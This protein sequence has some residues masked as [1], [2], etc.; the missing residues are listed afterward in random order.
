MLRANGH[1]PSEAFN[2][3]VEEAT[4]SLYSMSV[5][6]ACCMFQCVYMGSRRLVVLASHMWVTAFAEWDNQFLYS[7]IIS[8]Y[9]EGI[10]IAYNEMAQSAKIVIYE[11]ITNA[12][13]SLLL[14][15]T[16]GIF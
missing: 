7:L 11:S 2:E 15:F 5:Q 13:F 12:L 8:H 3:T 10:E 14:D 1:S 6:V 4:Q 9:I 16:L